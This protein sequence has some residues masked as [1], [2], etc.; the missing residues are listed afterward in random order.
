MIDETVKF[1]E[2]ELNIFFRLRFN[3]IEDRVVA[4]AIVNQD[5]SL[6]IRDENKVLISLVDI[7]EEGSLKNTGVQHSIRNGGFVKSP[8]P[9]HLN[10]YLMFSSLFSNGNYIESLKYVS[11]VILF[12]QSRTVFDRSTYPSLQNTS[13]EKLVFEMYHPDYQARNNL[14]STIGAKYIPSVIYKVKMLTIWEAEAAQVIPGIGT[15]DKNENA[16]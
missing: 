11:E 13:I 10:L 8:L 3:I 15:L 16:L 9:V 5:G 1:I 7:Q 4:S 14:W 2:K 6:A 12:F